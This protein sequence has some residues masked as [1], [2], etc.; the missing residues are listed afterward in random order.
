MIE[1]DP[2]RVERRPWSTGCVFAV[3]DEPVGVVATN[4]VSLFGEMNADLVCPA[5]FQLALNH[6]EVSQ[7]RHGEDM[8]DG[9]LT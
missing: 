2:H 7:W 3:A 4:R 8:S 6:R 9:V 1:R 5:G